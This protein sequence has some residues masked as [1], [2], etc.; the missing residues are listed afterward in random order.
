MRM[1]PW[2]GEPLVG[3]KIASLKQRWLVGYKWHR[4]FYPDCG[5]NSKQLVLLTRRPPQSN[6][7]STLALSVQRHSL[8]QLLSVDPTAVSWIRITWET[9]YR[10]LAERA[11]YARCLVLCVPFTASISRA[12][13]YEAKDTSLG[14]NKNGYS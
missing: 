13:Y 9:V 1:S 3:L 2:N 4:K 5:I 6:C 8:Q 14:Y 10:R 12:D 7:T 11:H